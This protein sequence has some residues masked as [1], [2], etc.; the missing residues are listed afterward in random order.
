MSFTLRQLQKT[1]SQSRQRMGTRMTTIDGYQAALIG[2]LAHLVT[3]NERFRNAFIRDGVAVN[4]CDCPSCSGRSRNADIQSKIDSW[5]SKYGSNAELSDVI[6]AETQNK[7][8]QSGAGAGS[9]TGNPNQQPPRPSSGQGSSHG[10][11]S[12]EHDQSD[13]ESAQP[14]GSAP[15]QPATGSAQTPAPPQQTPEQQVLQQAK[16]V[17]A[18]AIRAARQQPKSEKAQ[19]GLAQAKKLFKTARKQASFNRAAMASS[20]SLSARKRLTSA[21]GRL[22]RVPQKLRSQMAELI[23]RLVSQTGTTGLQLGPIPVLSARK[24]VNRMLVQR[25]LQNALKEDSVSGRPVTLFLPDVS[26]SCEAQAQIACDLANAASYAG[27]TGSDVLVFPHANGQVDRSEEYFPWLNGK[28]ITTNVAEIPQI[29][30]DVCGGRSRFTV[31]V[32]VF[33]GDHDAVDHYGSVAA[34]KTVLRAVWLHNYRDSSS[35]EGVTPVTAGSFLHPG[36]SSGVDRKLSM[37]AG[38]TSM[39][40]MLSGFDKAVKQ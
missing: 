13:N 12:P 24:L 33:I 18:D 15:D 10:G 7:S 29:F 22:R 36:W 4:S 5:T 31:R 11:E 21:H 28:P 9:G 40:S 39:A 6:A 30:D 27:L 25:P 26:P 17:L 20:P 8:Q 1:L 37:V 38:C 32:A 14:T 34:L 16:S 19:A 2:H 23:N 35:R 3:G